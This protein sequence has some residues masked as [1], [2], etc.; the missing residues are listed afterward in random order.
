MSSNTS[1]F[2]SADR[3]IESLDDDRL[4]RRAFALSTAQAIT[5]WQGDDSLVMALY[6]GWGDGKS[7]VKGMVVDA[8]KKDTATCP[9][10][11]HFN[12]WEWAGQNQ[13]AQVFFDEIGK[14]IAHQ[15]SAAE[16]QRAEECGN[17]L[18]KLGKYLNLT[19]SIVTPVMYAASLAFPVASIFTPVVSKVFKKS[20][21]LA[22]QAAEAVK[23]QTEREDTSLPKLKSELKDALK[24]LN[25]NVVVLVDDIDRLA[26]DEIKLLFQLIKANSD[27]PNLI[28]FLF[29]QRDIIE[30]ALEGTI[31]TGTGKDYLEKIVQVP[32]S[33]P[34][35]QRPLLEGFMDSK[36]HELLARRGLEKKFDWSR[37]KEMWQA[38][39]GGYFQNVRD[40]ARF[41]GTFEFQVAAFHDPAEFD[42]VDLFA[43]EVL[44]VFEDGVYES[45]AKSRHL[46]MAADSAL[47]SEGPSFDITAAWKKSIQQIVG[48]A[49][50]SRPEA[51][52]AVI[53]SLFPL[54]SF[55]LGLR[56]PDKLPLMQ[57]QS[58][59]SHPA[60]FG[61]Y[62]HLCI[63]QG[64]I[65]QTQ[66]LKLLKAISKPIEFKRILAEFDKQ[67]LALEA[68]TRLSAHADRFD[69]RHTGQIAGA[70]FDDCDLMVG[71]YSDSLWAGF[72]AMACVLIEAHLDKLASSADRFGVLKAAF[73]ATKGIYLPAS[74]LRREGSRANEYD[75]KWKSRGFSKDERGVLENEQLKELAQIC[76]RHFGEIAESGALKKHPKL[77]DILEWWLHWSRPSD[78][79]KVYFRKL[80][81]TDDGLAVLLEQYLGGKLSEDEH[82]KFIERLYNRGLSDFE[83]FMPVD[84]VKARVEDLAKKQ[85]SDYVAKLC[86]VFMDVYEEHV[87]NKTAFPEATPGQPAPA[88]E[89]KTPTTPPEVEGQDEGTVGNP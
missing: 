51:A 2:F 36:L 41:F 85:P 17:R 64:D 13:L 16:K 19:G 31:R 84:E 43:L 45:V 89:G 49:Q 44:R 39:L 7:S 8:M 4:Q 58:R 60:F 77:N 63:P 82:Q 23:E 55:L 28:F 40:A 86:S 21:D 88:P 65:P 14:Q 76:T 80:V 59:I 53:E 25:R 34:H 69:P 6:G 24:A 30:Q 48:G 67:R 71:Y 62:F 79:A 47:H 52:T 61:R 5:T 3:P 38:G 42:P 35:I 29:F 10:I 56:S 26:A 32:L 57:Q 22:E 74:L 1:H 11:V 12:P 81:A 20:G 72:T 54:Q 18:R 50:V 15:G 46:L 33:L 68:L 87:R 83:Q 73:E 70:L 75:K 78:A 27:F 37:F 66:L 9:F